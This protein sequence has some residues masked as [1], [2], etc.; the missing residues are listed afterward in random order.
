MKKLCSFILSLTLILTLASPAF[1]TETSS[2]ENWRVVTD[3]DGSIY[4]Q[5]DATNEI[6]VYAFRIDENGDEQSVDLVEY[7]HQLNT[8]SIIP[9]LV[10]STNEQSEQ[11]DQNDPISRKPGTSTYVYSYEETRSYRT[12]GSGIKVTPDVVGPATITYG[13]S[14]TVSD[15]FGGT[16]SIS[17]SMEDAIS[18][19]ASFEWHTELS[20]S[21]SF[22]VTHEIMAGRTGHVEF[23][24]YYNYSS[25]T[26]TQKLVH[27]PGGVISTKTYNAWGKSPI[28]LA[29]GFADGIYSVRY[30]L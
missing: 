29:T 7:A 14:V 23:T 21:S 6:I 12:L 17:A 1:A 16:I 18:G 3:E 30:S 13:E 15:E 22:S 11:N 19:A 5:N 20:S 8:A 25:G 10:G 27:I 28:I 9:T 26:L 24:P 4:L 2:S